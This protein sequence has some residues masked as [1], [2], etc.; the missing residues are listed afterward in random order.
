VSL[1]VSQMPDGTYFLV[2]TQ[3]LTKAEGVKLLAEIAIASK[4]NEAVIAE[5]ER[6]IKQLEQASLEFEQYDFNAV[7]I[8]NGLI[9][10]IKG[11]GKS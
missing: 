10:L 1:R 11:E 5:R 3:D 6:I 9:A 7:G 4:I 2:M 8:T